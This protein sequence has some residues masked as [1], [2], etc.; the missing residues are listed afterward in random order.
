MSDTVVISVPDAATRQLM[1]NVAKSHAYGNKRVEQEDLE[2]YLLLCWCEDFEQVSG[3]TSDVPYML[4]VFRH[5]S[6]DFVKG[7]DRVTNARGDKC[8][9]SEEQIKNLLPSIESPEDWANVAAATVTDGV[10]SKADPAHGNTAL[11]VYADM[12]KAW[13][14]L[15]RSDRDLLRERHILGQS[16]AEIAARSG[17]KRTT[18]TERVAAALERMQELLG[19]KPGQPDGV[20][21]RVMSNARAQVLTRTEY[22][23]D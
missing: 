6:L 3:H 4:G 7:V 13:E 5:W 2:A 14:G 20:G 1:V 15:S 17:Q 8:Y 22:A 23:G 12:R 10:R 11:A 21:R 18:V 16:A 19:G 9:Y